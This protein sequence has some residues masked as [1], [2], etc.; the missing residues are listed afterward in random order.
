MGA[1]DNIRYYDP[2]TAKL[3]ILKTDIFPAVQGN[4]NCSQ[5]VQDHAGMIEFTSE[6]GHT[7]FTVMLPLHEADAEKLPVEAGS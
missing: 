6:L 3:K 5:I 7:Q 2:A 4:L 1:P